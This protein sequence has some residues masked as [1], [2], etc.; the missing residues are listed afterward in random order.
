MAMP[1]IA[2][3]ILKAKVNLSNDAADAALEKGV[4]GSIAGCKIYVSNNVKTVEGSASVRHKCFV[5]TKRAIA[6]ADQLSEINAYRP[7][8]RFA[9]AVK[10]L[11]LYGAKV[12]YPNELVLLDVGFNTK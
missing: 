10:G 5:R 8:H 6:F 2:S 12:I 7:E 11:H 1:Q 4:L 9:D 3:L